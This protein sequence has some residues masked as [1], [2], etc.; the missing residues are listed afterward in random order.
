MSVLKSSLLFAVLLLFTLDISAQ[1][2]EDTIAI[3]KTALDYIE[4]YFYKDAKRMEKALHPELVKRS[5]QKTEDGTEF[6]INLGASYMVMRTAN[7]TNRHAANP[8]GT[9]E[10]I[11]EIYDIV[12]NAATVKVS[13]N[14]YNFIDY[15]HIGKFNNEWKIINVFW[16][17]LPV[18]EK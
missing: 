18:A 3:K 13:T 11:V 15:L 9:I 7:N 4:G 1:S 8:E 2:T 5:I 12:G 14:Q 10:S 6:I 17:N 16:A